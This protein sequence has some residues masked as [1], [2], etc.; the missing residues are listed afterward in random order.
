MFP[1]MLGNFEDQAVAVVVGFERT[2]SRRRKSLNHRCSTFSARQTLGMRL[3]FASGCRISASMLTTG[4]A[5]TFARAII[6]ISFKQTVLLEPP[7]YSEMKARC[8]I[9]ISSAHLTYGSQ[10]QPFFP[11]SRTICA[12]LL[13][14]QAPICPGMCLI[15]SYISFVTA[16]QPVRMSPV[17]LAHIES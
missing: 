15:S 17:T 13:L 1:E 5:R 8:E 6:D 9:C 14:M 7:L 12:S 2:F 4:N 16:M 11:T 10:F 3:H